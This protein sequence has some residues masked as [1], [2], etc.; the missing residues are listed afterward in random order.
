MTLESS[1]GLPDLVS[2]EVT[3]CN[4]CGVAVGS[5]KQCGSGCVEK[6]FKINGFI[7]VNEEIERHEAA[8]ERSCNDGRY[9]KTTERFEQND[10]CIP[11]PDP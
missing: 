7:K 8:G 10:V 2:N 3:A 11:D 5:T 4:E 6:K 9:Y 1:L